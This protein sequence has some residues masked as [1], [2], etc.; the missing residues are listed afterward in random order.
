[1]VLELEVCRVDLTRGVV[2]DREGDVQ[3]T[4]TTREVDLLRYLSERPSVPVTRDTLITEVW[5]YSDAVVTRVCDNT[6]SRLRAKIEANAQRPA[7]V[8][9]VHGSGYRF[10]PLQAQEVPQ[11]A[12]APSG[13]VLVLGPVR[14]DLARRQVVGPGGESTLTANEAAL[15]E[16]LMRAD[17]VVLDRQ[18]LIREVWGQGASRSVDSTVYRLR[19]K[20]EPD[21]SEPRYLVSER[22]G[23]YR[24]ALPQTPTV[25]DDRDSFVGRGQALECLGD[26]LQ[27][28]RWVV[29]TGAGG[30]GK[31]RLVR[32]GLAGQQPV[33]WV[34]L[35]SASTVPEVCAL[36][37]RVLEVHLTGDD[38]V[39]QIARALDWRGQGLLVLA[40]LEQAADAAAPLVQAWLQSAAQLRIV[41]TSRIRLG[42]DGEIAV[43]LEPLSP[44]EGVTLFVQ[45]ARAASSSF[46][47]SP[48]DEPAVQRLVEQ[49]DGLPLAIE[50]AAARAPTLG[51]ADLL[52]RLDQRLDLLARPRASTDR[53]RSLRAAIAASWQLLSDEEAR[54]LMLLSLFG[55]GFTLQDVDGLLGA[56]SVD[57]L[58]ALRDDCLVQ[59]RKEGRPFAILESIRAY[60]AEQRAATEDGGRAIELSWVRWLAEL[61]EPEFLDATGLI[62][63]EDEAARLNAAAGDLEEAA[64][65]A[66]RWREPVLGSRCVL[67]AMMVRHNEGPFGP[68]MAVADSLAELP[69]PELELGRLHMSR[70]MLLNPM[71]KPRE[72]GEAAAKAAELSERAQDPWTALQAYDALYVASLHLSHTD[73]VLQAARDASSAA[74]RAGRPD[75]A[76]WW[77]AHV[78]YFHNDHEGAYREVELTLE[79]AGKLG[80]RQMMAAALGRLGTLDLSMGR[81]GR[82]RARLEEAIDLFREARQPVSVQA[83]GLRL[84]DVLLATGDHAALEP[85][86]EELTQIAAQM[87]SGLP[88]AIVWLR[89][90]ESRVTRG[91]P[92][93][94]QSAQ[95]ARAGLRAVPIPE[96]E[97][98]LALQEARG[99]LGSGDLPS[100][101][102]LGREALDGLLAIERPSLARRA[103][104]TLAVALAALGELDEAWVHA[105]QATAGTAATHVRVVVLAQRG[106][107]AALRGDRPTAARALSEA[108][109]LARRSGLGQPTS[110]SGI[111][112]EKL[113]R[114]LA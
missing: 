36:V 67:A 65:R 107:V 100:A 38:A 92:S 106:Q 50:L 93:W 64:R 75:L 63:H 28:G 41:G 69:M 11:E 34:E 9:T 5:G 112:L 57:L 110:E 45:R 111:E 82:A 32:R 83:L 78:C 73:P 88:E 13:K 1:M 95:R 85:L 22:G 68:L 94:R 74:E 18:S 56:D 7:H 39:E 2:M 96:I 52:S 44:E 103:H 33:W 102:T 97:A 70:A 109:E 3:V 21:P 42:L 87:G 77:R 108:S 81:P 62:G 84:V 113:R 40:N 8:L 98:E 49:L 23:G 16:R 15:L 86:G 104:G 29:V 54:A 59:S 31:T 35:A 61:G 90:T 105:E 4:L 101:V 6:V 14:I 71:G 76:A 47:L 17:G 24:L 37:A 60:A 19:A 27:A 114:A 10:E 79:L 58:Q 99:H 72:A 89:C 25:R 91:E 66:L 48:R 46:R 30:I 20:I 53:H 12:P 80:E 51:V 26:A 43:E 55:N